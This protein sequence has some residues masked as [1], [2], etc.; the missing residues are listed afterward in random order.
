MRFGDLPPDR[1]AAAMRD[2]GCSLRFGPFVLRAQT[3]E[4]AVVDFAHHIYANHEL[5]EDEFADATVSV[6]TS[7]DV[8]RP[9]RRHARMFLDGAP[10][11]ASLAARLSC[12]MLEWG[13]NWVIASRA[14]TFLQIHSGAV[15]R[16]GRAVILPATSGSGKSTLCAN[17]I[18]SGWRLF[19]DEFAVLALDTGEVVPM[20][21]GVSLKN[22]SIEV[23]RQRHPREEFSRV[24]TKTPKGNVSILRAP[25]DSVL[26]AAERALPGAVVFPK[27]TEGRGLEVSR[28]PRGTA[29]ARLVQN[30]INYTALGERGFEAMVRLVETV[31]VFDLVYGDTAQALAWFDELAD[32]FG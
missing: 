27:W 6:V 21:R 18:G 31:P 7:W 32:G 22:Q 11:I 12:P 29:L 25:R 1:A 20:P 17:L 16:R 24:F 28:V 19:S 15:E 30:S 2:D 26:R 13:L 10:F 23:A 14:H 5:V 4:P 8:R 9:W 3:N